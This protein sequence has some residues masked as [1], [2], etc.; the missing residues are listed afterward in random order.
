MD[1]DRPDHMEPLRPPPEG[2]APG[3]NIEPLRPPPEGKSPGN[4][5]EPL[6]P[7]P[8]VGTV[9]PG[10]TDPLRP[11]FFFQVLREITTVFLKYTH[12]RI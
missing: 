3:D 5:V 12:A 10:N 1:M 8:A 4:N 7:F 11:I 2:E 9:K 6:R